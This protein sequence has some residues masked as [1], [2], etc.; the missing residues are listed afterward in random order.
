M[1]RLQITPSE[2]KVWS[3]SLDRT[4]SLCFPTLNINE[5]VESNNEVEK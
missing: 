1:R 5:R 3:L 4:H 2:S